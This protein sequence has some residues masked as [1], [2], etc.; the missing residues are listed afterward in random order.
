MLVITSVPNSRHHSPDPFHTPPALR[1]KKGEEGECPILKSVSRTIQMEIHANICMYIRTNI[2]IRMH[3][4]T[5]LH[6]ISWA[7]HNT[8]ERHQPIAPCA[9]LY[10]PICV[11]RHGA[12]WNSHFS[13]CHRSNLISIFVPSIAIQCLQ[14]SPVSN[15][16]FMCSHQFTRLL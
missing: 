6:R 16:I 3:A 10:T 9:Y 12:Y 4:K 8:M 2:H 15:M 1:E 5:Q 11:V 13:S 7:P 14:S